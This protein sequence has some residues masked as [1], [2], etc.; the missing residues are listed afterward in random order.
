[1]TAAAVSRGLTIVID[2]ARFP[3]A[4]VNINSVRGHTR[5]TSEAV[6]PWKALG[7]LLGR[8]QRPVQTPVVISYWFR[9]DD[10]V[11][12]DSSN[13]F[14][15]AKAFTDGLVAAGVIP[16]DNDALVVVTRLGRDWSPGGRR[17][18]VTLRPASSGDTPPAIP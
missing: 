9:F 6:K 8:G 18:V 17:I 16:D 15:T 7:L 5:F 14:P 4:L 11:H 10:E 3:G 12:R 1:M 2:A 13:Y